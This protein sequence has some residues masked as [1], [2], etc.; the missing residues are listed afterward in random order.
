MYR[1]DDSD[2]RMCASQLNSALQHAHLELLGA[3]CATHQLRLHYS[4]DKLIRFGRRDVLRKSAQAASA[5]HEY[6]S[7]IEKKIPDTAPEPPSPI[8]TSEQVAQAVQWP[9]SYLR[10]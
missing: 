7:A 1:H 5:L 10:E 9:C 2:E 3:H 6:Y 8:P 4:T